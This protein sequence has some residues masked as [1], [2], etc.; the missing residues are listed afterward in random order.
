MHQAPSLLPP[1]VV[2]GLAEVVFVVDLGAVFVV[3]LVAL[4]SGAASS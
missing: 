3:D 4:V 1:L 2:H